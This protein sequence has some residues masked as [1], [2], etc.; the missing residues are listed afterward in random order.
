MPD[1]IVVNDMEDLRRKP[2]Q[3]EKNIEEGRVYDAKEVMDILREKY[4]I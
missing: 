1:R 4:G 2:E 3:A